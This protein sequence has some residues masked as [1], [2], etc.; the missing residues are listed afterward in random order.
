M[1]YAHNKLKVKLKYAYALFNLYNLHSKR[2]WIN[3]W[4]AF[5]LKKD[6]D[7]I[8]DKINESNHY[9]NYHTGKYNKK[10]NI[11]N[12]T[13][14]NAARLKS[15]SPLKNMNVHNNTTSTTT[16]NT[17]QYDTFLN[18]QEKFS[19]RVKQK[20]QMNTN[21]IEEEL[22]LLYTF[23]PKVNTRP[24][25]S[26][27]ISTNT[28][29]YVDR[30]IPSSN[31]LHTASNNMNMRSNIERCVSPT[32]SKKQSSFDRL[33]RNSSAKMKQKNLS[34]KASNKSFNVKKA[35][36]SKAKIDKLHKD[37]K[38][39][40]NKKK[41]LQKKI[42]ED[43]G[44][45][46]K[47]K[48]F[49]ANSGYVVDS[50]FEER[51]KKLIEDRNNFVFV[52][53]YLRQCKFNEHVLGGSNSNKLLKEYIVKNNV[54]IENL[55]QKQSQANQMMVN[56]E[57]GNEYNNENGAVFEEEGMNGENEQRD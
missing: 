19:Q 6:Y 52:Y 38:T 44:I 30:N 29:N 23:S 32:V 12:N 17:N 57:E 26:Y 55:M 3:K 43:M 56:E 42:D 8:F 27:N 31:N 25:H 45:T 47:P 37:Y 10:L 24:L 53:D 21:K 49:T 41:D 39:Y 13:N 11:N 15:A 36:H 16:N 5:S 20:K 40:E 7:L 48:S 2:T 18:R 1:K 35:V 50:N 9:N 14:N 34:S 28:N 46:F 51:N 22:H 54:E 33:Y 4:K